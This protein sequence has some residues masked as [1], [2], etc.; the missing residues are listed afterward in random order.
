MNI[1][2]IYAGGINLLSKFTAVIFFIAAFFVIGCNTCDNGNGPGSGEPELAVY[3]TSLPLNGTTPAVYR[4]LPDG[5]EQ[6][7][8]ISNG[9]I[10]SPPS[11]NGMIAFLR[12]ENGINN[13][14]TFDRNSGTEKLIESDNQ[15]FSIAYPVMSNDGNKIAF[16]GG[17]SQLFIY[18]LDNFSIEKVAGNMYDGSI[19]SFSESGN[20]LAYFAS[21]GDGSFAVKIVSSDNTENVVW[22]RTF[23]GELNSGSLE[24]TI[25][26]QNNGE[27]IVFGY[28]MGDKDMIAIV[29]PS[30][31]EPE[32]LE[33]QE[34]L[35]GARMPDI[36]N[37]NEFVCFVSSDGEILARN[38]SGEPQFSTL[39]ENTIDSRYFM[40]DWSPNDNYVI[41]NKYFTGETQISSSDIIVLKIIKNGSFAIAE[42][43]YLISNNTFRAFWKID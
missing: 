3:F 23:Q 27:N 17:E 7:E 39:V 8:I 1:R 10:Y 21:V 42:D 24:P 29:D 28:S 4:A 16:F 20:M 15:Q 33:F 34:G 41:V 35:P 14:Y 13:L 38:I 36:S 43:N 5:T 30:I 12:K 19:P 18:R 31:Q 37:D 11:D 6:T 9:I 26:W 2:R 22:N 32:I 40:P 25:K